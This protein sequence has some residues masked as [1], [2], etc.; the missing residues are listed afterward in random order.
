MGLDLVQEV[1]PDPEHIPA[2]ALVPARVEDAAAP[3]VPVPDQPVV[4]VHQPLVVPVP[5]PVTVPE[6]GTPVFVSVRRPQPAAAR[7]RS[8]QTTG[9]AVALTVVCMAGTGFLCGWH[10]PGLQMALESLGLAL[11][12]AGTVVAV[13]RHTRDR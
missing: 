8:P 1:S 10:G 7:R 12:S 9:T 11:G 5:V 4:P 13:R 2:P 6:P 3:P